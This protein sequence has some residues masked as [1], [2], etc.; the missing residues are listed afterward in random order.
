MWKGDNKKYLKAVKSHHFQQIRL[1]KIWRNQRTN[2]TKAPFNQ[3]YNYLPCLLW[4]SIE[5]KENRNE[6]NEN[7]VQVKPI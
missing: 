6:L 2:K 5:K 3:Q 1:K 4:L 7:F